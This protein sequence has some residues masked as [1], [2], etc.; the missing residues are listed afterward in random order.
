MYAGPTAMKN[1]VQMMAKP[2]PWE[3]PVQS[4]CTAPVPSKRSL[5]AMRMM[6]GF[7]NTAKMTIDGVVGVSYRFSSS[8]FQ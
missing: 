5:H 6:Q 8:K 7:S 4:F 1:I 3:G 2:V